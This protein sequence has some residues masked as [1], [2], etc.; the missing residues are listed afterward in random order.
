MEM[1]PKVL[2][3]TTTVFYEY[4]SLML[5]VAV[6]GA[7]GLT[8]WLTLSLPRQSKVQ[9][10]NHNKTM[11]TLERDPDLVRQHTATFRILDHQDATLWVS[12]S[13]LCLIWLRAPSESRRTEPE[14]ALYQPT[15]VKGWLTCWVDPAHWRA[16]LNIM[17]RLQLALKGEGPWASLAY[18]HGLTLQQSP[19]GLPMLEGYMEDR[20]LQIEA[21]GTSLRV[22]AAVDPSLRMVPGSGHSGNPVLDACM[23]SAGVPEHLIAPMLQLLH[24]QGGRC[25]DGQLYT[26]LHGSVDE[27]MQALEPI[28]AYRRPAPTAPATS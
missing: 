26:E 16:P 9:F 15:A 11:A 12:P 28:L 5:A 3:Y 6:A 21:T 4:F 27:L 14:G 25:S 7:T 22:N 2:R 13:G 18:Q 8:A 19:Q 24:S 23:D 1:R 17:V 20:L 10:A